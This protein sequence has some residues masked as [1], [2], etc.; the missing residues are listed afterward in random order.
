MPSE[1]AGLVFVSAPCVHGTIHICHAA[2]PTDKVASETVMVSQHLLLDYLADSGQQRDA[3]L[4]ESA[5]SFLVCRMFV[6]DLSSI[7]RS[8]MGPAKLQQSEK[9]LQYQKL[10]QQAQ[11]AE[12]C[13]LEAGV[14]FSG[15]ASLPGAI[16]LSAGAAL[17]TGIGWCSLAL[18]TVL[19]AC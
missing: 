6:D 4:A 7:H 2:G 15:T 17:P 11:K 18:P 19:A 12:S 1:P 10:E 5:R 14:S 8:G 3:A 13:D 16:D 9:L